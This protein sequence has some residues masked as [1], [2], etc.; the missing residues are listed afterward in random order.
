MNIDGEINKLLA[1]R[2]FGN[3]C[4]GPDC[5]LDTFRAEIK[6]V[7][8]KAVKEARELEMGFQRSLIRQHFSIHHGNLKHPDCVLCEMQK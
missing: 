5:K 1:Q 4:S 7:V 2:C 6:A 3:S 8:E